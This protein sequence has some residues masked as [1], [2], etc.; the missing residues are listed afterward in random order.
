ML[1][2][3]NVFRL[4]F[5]ELSVGHSELAVLDRYFSLAV[6]EHQDQKQLGLES[7]SFTYTWAF[8]TEGKSKQDLKQSRH[9]RQEGANAVASVACQS[10]R[11]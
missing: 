4:I 3:G 7:I 9:L 2:E 8:L 11:I 10:R 6:V 1:K 5:Q